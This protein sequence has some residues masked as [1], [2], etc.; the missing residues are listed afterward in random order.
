M[1]QREKF[2]VVHL[3]EPFSGFVPLNVL[4]QTAAMGTPNVATFHSFQGTWLYHVGVKR[5]VMRHF[6]MLQ[7]RIAVSP[8]A[9]RYISG[10]F[11]AGYRIIP[12]G[13]D[14]EEFATAEPFPHLRDGMINLLFVGRLEKRKGLKYLLGA[15]S[16][17]KWDWP[18]LRLLVVG[19][20]NPDEDSY[21]IMSERN[22]KD[23]E[24]LGRVTDEEKARYFKSADIFCS[25]ATGRE[26]FG[27][28]LLEAMA[29]G[30]PVVAT[31]IDGYASVITHGEE[32]LLV[33]PKSDKALADAISS[34]I[35]APQL[36]ASLA[37]RGRKKANEYRWEIVA[38]KV[39]DY[40]ETLLESRQP[41]VVR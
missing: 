5:V 19:A 6:R 31:N 26:S 35:D 40:Y 17:L 28:V 11:P 20:G 33:E 27:I 13:I 4:S 22:L 9:Y 12:N 2:D 1:L 14:V 32:G 41:A 39:M 37:E 16:M 7:G 21:R 25:P 15:F 24:F 30:K 23:V 29:A 18:N 36:R 38:G 34:L 10:H 3:H 8:P